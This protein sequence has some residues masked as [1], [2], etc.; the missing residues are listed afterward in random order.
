MSHSEIYGH[1][2]LYD[3]AFSFKDVVSEADAVLAMA[4]AAGVGKPEAFLELAAGPARNALEFSKRG[5]RATAVDNNPGMVRFAQ[6]TAAEEGLD[7][8]MV[9]ADMTDFSIDAPVDIAAI[10]MG[11]IGIILDNDSLL[12]HLDR[13]ADALVPGGVYIIEHEHPRDVFKVGVS[14]G[15]DWEMERD[16]LTLHT[17]WGRP[18]DVFDPTTQIIEH[19]VSFTWQRDGE[20]NET[21][22]VRPD[23]AITPNELRALVK[24]S[25]RFEIAAEYGSLDPAIP[26]SNAEES[27]RYVPVLQRL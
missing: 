16:G 14:A 25:G 9:E 26:F 18:G 19:T 4:A 27:W 2:E 5:L 22:E 13:V 23:R 1:A 17:R 12:R 8:A 21:V 10:F 15:S 3:L 20:R 7:L 11:S 6:E 24:A